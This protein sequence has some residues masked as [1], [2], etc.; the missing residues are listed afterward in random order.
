MELRKHPLMRHDEK[1]NWPPVWTRA[2]IGAPERGL[3][4]EF[5]T[6]K[7]VKC[8]TITTGKCFLMMEHESQDYVGTLL[9]DDGLFCWLLSVELKQHI[10]KSLKEIG[11]LE[12][13]YSPIQDLKKTA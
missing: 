5:G 10:G 3:R 6:L 8:D 4:G 9:F 7:R 1:S 13:S 12:L 2:S 11:Y